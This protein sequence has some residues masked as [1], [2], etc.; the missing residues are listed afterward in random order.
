MAGSLASFWQS[1][2]KKLFLQVLVGL[3]GD[4]EAGHCQV[5]YYTRPGEEFEELPDLTRAREEHPRRYYS[6]NAA[7]RK[8]SATG[9][10]QQG[11]RP[12]FRA[13]AAAAACLM[14]LVVLGA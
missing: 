4:E 2:E 6:T 10:T 5:H 8:L 7:E 12:R 9:G 13:M 11:Q 14:Q 1:F 3:E